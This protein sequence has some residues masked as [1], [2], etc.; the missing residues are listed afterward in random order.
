MERPHAAVSTDTGDRRFLDIGYNFLSLAG[1]ALILASI[2]S[3]DTT[4]PFPG[5][6]ALLPVAGTL[7]I[8]ATPG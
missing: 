3:F 2:V 1:L 7:L 5:W 4:T 6:P 8:L